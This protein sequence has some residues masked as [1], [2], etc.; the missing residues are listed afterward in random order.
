MQNSLVRNVP[1]LVRH[2]KKAMPAHGRSAVWYTTYVLWERS[3]RLALLPVSGIKGGVPVATR[4][5]YRVLIVDDERFA[6]QLTQL[7]ARAASAEISIQG[8]LISSSLN[9]AAAQ[10]EQSDFIFIDPFAFG[11]ADAVRFIA[12][13]QARWPAKAVALVRSE[14]R[15]QERQR[16]LEGLALSPLR[17]RTLPAIDT[18]IASE[19][20]FIQALRAVLASLAR[21]VQQA[22]FDPARSGLNDLRSPGAF[23]AGLRP[24]TWFAGADAPT[25]RADFGTSNAGQLSAAQVQAMIDQAVAVALATRPPTPSRPLN[26]P[27]SAD[28]A[29]LVPQVQ[30]HVTALQQQV[31]GLQAAVSAQQEAHARSDEQATAAQREVRE[32][33]RSANGLEQRMQSSETRLQR[34]EAQV[35]ALQALQRV[36]A[37]VA[38]VIGLAG[39]VLGMLALAKH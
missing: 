15:W 32:L 14:R 11:L 24:G 19:A 7:L 4:L 30:Q 18:D 13:V 38:M 31:L 8:Y 33:N 23:D 26:A 12:E 37:V 29:T 10:V 17:L 5:G 28:L 1:H 20:A 9:A 16:D 22:G 6:T 35:S 39:G 2:A 27:G 36:L 34:M 21:E 25:V 3:N